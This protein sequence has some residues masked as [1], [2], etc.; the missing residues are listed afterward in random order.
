M[1]LRPAD[2]P[3]TPDE[4]FGWREEAERFLAAEDAK[5]AEEK[6]KQRTLPKWTRVCTYDL[7]RALD[8]QFKVTAD[9][10]WGKFGTIGTEKAKL[11]SQRPRI[12]VSIDMGPDNLCRESRKAR[13]NQFIG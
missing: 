13:R 8:W 1:H 12:T 10:G 11:I 3:F 5:V 6:A 7:V 2:V 9:M 4:V